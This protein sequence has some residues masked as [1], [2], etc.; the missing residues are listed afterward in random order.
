MQM[1]LH[2]KDLTVIAVNMYQ[3]YCQRH[4]CLLTYEALHV[5]TL[6]V[7]R[8]QLLTCNARSHIYIH[9]VQK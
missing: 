6:H 7:S 2:W 5:S 3:F 4:N 8:T 9:I 1:C